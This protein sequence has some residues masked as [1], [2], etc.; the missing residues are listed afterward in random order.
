MPLARLPAQLRAAG[1]A[2]GGPLTV[3]VKNASYPEWTR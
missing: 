2:L 3:L 1:G